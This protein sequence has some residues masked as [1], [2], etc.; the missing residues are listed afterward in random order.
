MELMTKDALYI[1]LIGHVIGDFYLQ[2][3]KL[4]IKKNESFK[5]LLKHSFIYFISMVVVTIPIFSLSIMKW[6]CIISIAH[7]I[8][9][10]L[11]YIFKK[12]IVTDDRIEAVVYCGDQIIHII[13]IIF[14]AIA[15]LIS[16]E[17]VSY[18]YSVQYL[19]GT[20]QINA[21]NILSWI[22][23]LLIIIQP[24]SIT[25]KKVLYRYKPS[26]NEE[27][28]GIPNAGAVI[29]M[30]ERCIILLM[31]SV[32]QYAAI[33]FVLTAKSIARYNKIVEDPKFSEYYLLG[34]LLS[35][36]L[37]IAAYLLIF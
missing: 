37:V 11:K 23:I 10:S 28:G 32:N 4:A 22:L 25:L 27:D 36:M 33:G 5:I 12:K 15:I 13:L 16:S 29:G 34:T 17:P 26:I 7:F 18:I 30:L 2:S 21:T 6:I 3:S 1:F 19:L 8:V 20:L 9:D 31:L 24:F 14:V 35:T